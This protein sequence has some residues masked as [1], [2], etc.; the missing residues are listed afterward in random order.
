MTADSEKKHG[1]QFSIYLPVKTQ[2]QIDFIVAKT[3]TSRSA[4]VAIAVLNLYETMREAE[5]T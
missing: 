1:R 4:V 3:G 5:D 2:E